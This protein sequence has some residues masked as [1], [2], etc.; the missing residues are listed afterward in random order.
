LPQGDFQGKAIAIGVAA[1]E[2]HTN[3]GAQNQY[4][5]N[6]KKLTA[7]ALDE[8]KG[9]ASGI[10]TVYSNNTVSVILKGNRLVFSGEF[11]SASIFSVSGQSL[12]TYNATQIAAGISVENLQKG[13]YLVALTGANGQKT[14]AKFVK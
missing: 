11:A 12:G 2:W 7:N 3:S 1:Y 5:D 9:T 4:L 8:L 13:I 10:N 6:I 14:N